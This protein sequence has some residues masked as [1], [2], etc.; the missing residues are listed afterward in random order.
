M[1]DTTCTNAPTA[2]LLGWRVTTSTAGNRQPPARG[3]RPSRGPQSPHSRYG[4]SCRSGTLA[5]GI[6]Q[7]HDGAW[8][9]IAAAAVVLLAAL[10][11]SIAG[12]AFAVIAGSALAYL[13]GSIRCRR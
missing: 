6:A 1:E 10:V 11:S 7:Q 5:S 9:A 13:R 12:F 3:C 2:E 8:I 4:R